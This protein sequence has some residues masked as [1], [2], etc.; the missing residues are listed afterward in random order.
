MVL[1]CARYPLQA[2]DRNATSE[3]MLQKLDWSLLI[4]LANHHGL[5]P[6][7]FR[8]LDD[9]D[10]STAIPQEV[11][12]KLRLSY[13]STL[14]SNKN[15]LSN[16]MPV[17]DRFFEN[18]IPV[19][20]LKGPALCESVYTDLGLRPFGDIDM[21]VPQKDVP[22]GKVLMEE[23]G[24]QII[25]NCYYPIPDIK[26]EQ[27]G[28]EW[29]YQKEGRLVELHWGLINTL[30]PFALDISYFWKNTHEV[31]AGGRSVLVMDPDAQLMHLCLHQFSHHWKHLR[32]L[33]DIALVMEKS[34]EDIDWNE[35]ARAARVQKLERCIF[36]NLLL[37][38]KV[39]GMPFDE[40]A[41]ANLFQMKMPGYVARTMIDIIS[42]NILE[43][44]LPRRLWEALLVDGFRKKATIVASTFAHPFPRKEIGGQVAPSS[45]P[46]IKKKVV[47]ALKS[48]YYYRGLMVSFLRSIV[49]TSN[50]GRK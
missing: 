16:F 21:L 19:I 6:M 3:L 14:M 35:L 24:Y 1:A 34:S 25:P 30:S 36:Y 7:M 43:K 47:T 50:N 11:M 26:N 28:C 32:D 49:R 23:L 40:R 8:M 42:E 12:E 10:A 27:I 39:L 44:H 18:K 20:L 46:G 31:A 45:K 37:A 33:T 2:F 48:T 41:T 4:D 29:S 13:L 38:H 5:A 22:K 9:M 15:Q 17:L